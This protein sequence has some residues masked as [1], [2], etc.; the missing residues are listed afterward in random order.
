MEK[1]QEV[2]GQVHSSSSKGPSASGPSRARSQIQKKFPEFAPH[3]E[4]V[5]GFSAGPSAPGMSFSIIDDF[6]SPGLQKWR[7]YLEDMARHLFHQRRQRPFPCR[8]PQTH[9]GYVFA[10]TFTVSD[11]SPAFDSPSCWL[12]PPLFFAPRALRFGP[13]AI[14]T[15]VG[16]APLLVFFA[17][18]LAGFCL[19][20]RGLLLVV[21]GPWERLITVKDVVDAT[22]N[23]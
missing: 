7:D 10:R 21:V 16:A 19:G 9:T 4:F 1:G 5:G 18:P 15:N 23:G 20:T 12:T 17:P 13:L 22:K 14:E 3:Y 2:A 11:V 8:A 6:P